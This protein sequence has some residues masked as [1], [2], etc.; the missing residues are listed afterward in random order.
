VEGKGTLQE[1]AG[2]EAQRVI[3]LKEAKGTGR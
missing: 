3:Q 2:A 1:G